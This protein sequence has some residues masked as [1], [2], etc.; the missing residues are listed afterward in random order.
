M[1]NQK[2]LPFK[3]PGDYFETFPDSLSDRISRMEAEEVPVKRLGNKRILLAVAAAVAALALLTVP[4]VR[5]LSPGTAANDTFIEIALL[6]GAGLFSND[7]ELASYLDETAE[8]MGDEEAFL[9]QAADYLAS[10]DVEMDLI[11]E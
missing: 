1:K 10:M 5:M 9:T 4:M 7:Y 2:D 8:A 3:V 11:F 6:E